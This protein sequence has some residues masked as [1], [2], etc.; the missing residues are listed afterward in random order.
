MSD[1]AAD[2]TPTYLEDHG[3]KSVPQSVAYGYTASGYGFVQDM[4]YAY[5]HE[6]T[7]TSMAG[8]IRRFK[9]G[10][11]SFWQKISKSL[12]VKVLCSSEVLAV[13]RNSLGVSIDVKNSKGD[14]EV[15]E[16][17]KIIMSGAFPFK[18]G[19]TYR[20]PVSNPIGLSSSVRPSF[21][22]FFPHFSSFSAFP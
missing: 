21:L 15:M 19:K 16:F 11:T 10:Y 3:F 12:R 9:G 13:R 4:P 20:S 5:I 7:R 1:L 2:L 22:F 18:N 8:K 17:D 6:F 14:S